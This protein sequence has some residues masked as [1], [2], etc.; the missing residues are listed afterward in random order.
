MSTKTPAEYKVTLTIAVKQ[1]LNPYFLLN[2][3]TS[4]REHKLLGQVVMVTW[5]PLH[6]NEVN[7]KVK[8]TK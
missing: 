3:T 6:F 5:S 2:P 8:H 1:I 7:K 4:N